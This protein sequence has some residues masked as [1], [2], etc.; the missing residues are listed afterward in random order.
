MRRPRSTFA[1]LFARWKA[2]TPM[3]YRIAQVVLGGYASTFAG[4]VLA[5]EGPAPLWWH[6]LGQTLTIASV[7]CQLGANPAL[8]T[9]DTETPAPDAPN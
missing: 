3:V 7:L 2:P 9:D 5:H 1:R 8:P 6:L 4:L